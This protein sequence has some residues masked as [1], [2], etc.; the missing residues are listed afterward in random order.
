MQVLFHFTSFFDKNIHFNFFDIK[1]KI[2]EIAH[3][4]MNNFFTGFLGLF[5]KSCHSEKYVA[6][7][8]FS[9]LFFPKTSNFLA[10]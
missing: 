7:Y 3:K 1:K 6:F 10:S 4:I 8:E 9:K 2:S 5:R